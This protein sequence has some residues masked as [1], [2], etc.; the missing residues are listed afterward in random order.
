MLNV[1]FHKIFHNRIIVFNY[2]LLYIHI[3]AI[4]KI[5]SYITSYY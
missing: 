3:L 2:K 1:N 5:I 4:L